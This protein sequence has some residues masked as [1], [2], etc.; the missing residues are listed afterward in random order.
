MVFHSWLTFELK[1]A[2]FDSLTKLSVICTVEA[3]YD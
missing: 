1:F 3:I 2:V